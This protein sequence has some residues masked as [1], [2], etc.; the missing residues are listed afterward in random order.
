MS[1]TGIGY[2]DTAGLVLLN[3][4]AKYEYINESQEIKID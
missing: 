3:K 4:G 2:L 1:D